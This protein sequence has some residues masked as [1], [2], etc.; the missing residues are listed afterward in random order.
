[1]ITFKQKFTFIFCLK[2]SEVFTGMSYK[3]YD[4]IYSKGASIVLPYAPVF[5]EDKCLQVGS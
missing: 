1:M 5:S 3:S 2:T 4:T